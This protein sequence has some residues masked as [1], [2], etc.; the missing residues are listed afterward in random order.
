MKLRAKMEIRDEAL[1]DL[2]CSGTSLSMLNLASCVVKTSDFSNANPTGASFFQT[3]ISSCNFLGAQMTYCSLKMLTFSGCKF[4]LTNFMYSKLSNVTFV[5]CDFREVDF[6]QCE[7]DTVTFQDCT[8][9]AV[10]LTS[11][12]TKGKINVSSSTIFSMQGLSTLKGIVI[13]EGQLYVVAPL[14]A[15]EL[16][17]TIQQD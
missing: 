1:S 5:Q 16:G 14:L 8:L 15:L 13:S 2:T 11:V 4:E 7:F 9:D 3:N 12:K 17:I 6:R 10:N